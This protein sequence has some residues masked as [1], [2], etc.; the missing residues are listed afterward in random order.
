MVW[1]SRKK[2]F[3]SDPVTKRGMGGKGRATK[4][5]LFAAS[6]IY[7]VKQSYSSSVPKLFYPL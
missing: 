4:K 2:D 3:F 6:T 5:E 1:G 7:P